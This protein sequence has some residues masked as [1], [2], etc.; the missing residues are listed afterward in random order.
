MC[1]KKNTD[2]IATDALLG[3]SFLYRNPKGKTLD[4]RY[5]PFNQYVDLLKLNG[6]YPYSR[7]VDS[8]LGAEVHLRNTWADED[9]PCLNFGSQDYMGMTS[10]PAVMQ[11]AHQ[12]HIR[13]LLHQWNLSR[14]SIVSSCISQHLGISPDLH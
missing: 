1:A 13:L 12:R 5:K 11:A 7:T 10:H 6:V 4:E 8:K 3:G 14:Y 9:M 2:T